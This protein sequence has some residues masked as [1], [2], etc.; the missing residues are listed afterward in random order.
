M[1][2]VD[3]TLREGQQ[4]PLLFEAKKYRFSLAE[5][6]LLLRELLELGI[7]RFEFFSPIV[8][9]AEKE[10]FIQL[11]KFLKK[12][13]KKAILLAHCRCQERDIKEA[14]DAGFDGLHLYM[15]ISRPAL[16]SYRISEEEAKSK[17]I[18]ILQRTRGKYPKIYLKF[19][20]EDAFR[21]KSAEI[22]SLLNKIHNYIDTVGLPDTTGIATSRDVKEKIKLIRSKYHKLKI[23]VHFHNDRGLAL[24][25]AISAIEKGV[26]FVDVAIW[27]MGERSGIVSLSALLLNLYHTKRFITRKYNLK[28]LFPINQLMEKILGLRMPFNEPVSQYNRTH[29]AGVHQGAILE[30]YLRYEA[31]SLEIFGVKEKRFLLGPFTGWHSIYHYL[32]DVLKYDVTEEE[33][34]LICG[35][36]KDLFVKNINKEP[37]L[38]LKM[39][40]KKII[41]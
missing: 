23:E 6:R 32:R 9:N 16:S 39:L 30:G 14:I 17:I 15:G 18:E 11:K 35:K 19:S 22:V 38:L 28:K 33:A 36:F 13:K 20:V 12:V 26:D 24:S 37:N 41:K 10:D 4:S 5:K 8:N 7:S 34:K 1:E 21:T 27:G 2:L 29:V 25:N 3:T 40:A 31:N